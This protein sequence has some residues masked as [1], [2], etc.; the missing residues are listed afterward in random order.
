MHP[1]IASAPRFASGF[2][3][4]TAHSGAAVLA[5]SLTSGAWAGEYWHTADIIADISYANGTAQ[6]S[7]DSLVPAFDDSYGQ[8]VS[9]HVYWEMQIYGTMTSPV[10]VSEYPSVDAFVSAQSGDQAIGLGPA[11]FAMGDPWD[12][13]TSSTGIVQFFPWGSTDLSPAEF[14][15]IEG[16]ALGGGGAVHFAD[17]AGSLNVNLS[18]QGSVLFM[19]NYSTVPAPGALALFGCAGLLGRRRRGA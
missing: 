18:L 14:Y 15:G 10:P 17:E 3:R 1:L 4:V 19:F 9:V 2:S 11:Y 5:A 12:S 8:L 7:F 16:N 13:S 6:F